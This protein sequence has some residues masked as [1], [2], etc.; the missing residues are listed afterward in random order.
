MSSSDGELLLAEATAPEDRGS[1]HPRGHPNRL[2]AARP[3]NRWRGPNRL[4]YQSDQSAGT[5]PGLHW[6]TRSARMDGT[7]AHQAA[8]RMDPP[9]TGTTTAMAA[10][11]P[12]PTG[13][14][15]SANGTR[16]PSTM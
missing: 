2:P 11:Q 4:R 14:G 9:C 3:D 7:A 13:I 10:D 16:P 1:S 15:S 8:R 5:W 12:R 6:P